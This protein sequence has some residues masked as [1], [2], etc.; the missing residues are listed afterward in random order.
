LRPISASVAPFSTAQGKL[1]RY[2]PV[3][4]LR[5]SGRA[6]WVLSEWGIESQ[7]I[8]LFD[9]SGKGARKLTSAEI[10]GC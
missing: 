9:V 10:S 2:T 3:G 4:I 6:I 5:V 7:T 8:V 1:P